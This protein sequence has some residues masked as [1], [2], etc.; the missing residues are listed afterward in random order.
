MR[1]VNWFGFCWREG[2]NFTGTLDRFQRLELFFI[3]TVTVLADKCRAPQNY[4][5]PHGN[6]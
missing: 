5:C 3:I 1:S 6:T 2:Q 4:I